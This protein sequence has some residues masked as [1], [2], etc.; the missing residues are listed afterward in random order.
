MGQVSAADV[1]LLKVFRAVV[2]CGGLSAAE[3]E[4]NLGRST[5]S[6]H[7]KDLEQRLGLTLCR[8]GRS[9]FQLSDEGR[10]IYEDACRLLESLEQFRVNVAQ[11]HDHLSGRLSLGLFDKTATNPTAHIAKAMH[12]FREQAPG[13]ELEI[14]VGQLN[15]L[16]PAVLDGRMQLA[17]VPEH[18][19]SD[20][21]E[22]TPLFEEPMRLYCG[23]SHPLSMTI[24]APDIAAVRRHAY[25]GLSFHSPNMEASQRL[26]LQ[27]RASVNDQEAVAI[28][29]LSGDFVGFLPSHYANQFVQQGAMRCIEHEQLQYLVKFVAITRKS[30]KISRVTAAMLAALREAHGSESFSQ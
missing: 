13:V 1:R 28:L 8:R 30:P 14:T 4:L 17:V 7:L 15:S 9:G 26:Q 3:L 2:D 12:R 6:R 27:R 21:L 22:Y 29:I 23:A 25:A 18:R 16:E 24:A 5:V 10:R 19:R 11:M 20:S